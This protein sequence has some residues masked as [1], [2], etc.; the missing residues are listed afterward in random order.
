ML[1]V[2]AIVGDVATIAS[3]VVV[4]VAIVSSTAF[5]VHVVVDVVDD[6]APLPLVVVAAG[7]DYTTHKKVASLEAIG[8][9]AVAVVISL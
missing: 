7:V 6:V 1:L 8:L 2:I 4:D 3:V 5:Y 9:L